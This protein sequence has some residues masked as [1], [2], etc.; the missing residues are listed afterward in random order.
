MFYEKDYPE[1]VKHL[2]IAMVSKWG[3]SLVVTD[4]DIWEV[5]KESKEPPHIGNIVS[6]LIFEKLV[7]KLKEYFNEDLTTINYIVNGLDTH[8]YLD[9]ESYTNLEDIVKFLEHAQDHYDKEFE[10]L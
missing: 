2:H 6:G 1:W 7:D 4:D 5:A 10:E 8:F 3:L 9:N